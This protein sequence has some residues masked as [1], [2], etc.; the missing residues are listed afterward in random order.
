MTAG[1]FAF[2][3]VTATLLTLPVYAAPM[4]EAHPVA[5][6]ID[7][8]SLGSVVDPVGDAV[9]V[10]DGE[11]QPSGVAE[12]VAKG[13]VPETT[14]PETTTPESTPAS[15][16]VPD[17]GGE[18]AGVPALTV[19]QEGAE[20]FSSVGVTWREDASVTDVVVQLRV[21]GTD[22]A[23]DEWTSLE[24]DDA[25]QNE[26]AAT[27]G[28]VRAGTAPYWTGEAQGVQVIVQAEDGD[29]PEDVR[30]ALIDPGHSA[31]DDLATA[32][33]TATAHAGAAEPRIYTR[34]E[35]GADERIRSW[36]PEYVST[37]KAA[38]VHHTADGNN[39]SAEQVPAILRSMYAYHA[40]TR[41]WG[42]IGYN[43][44]VDRYGRVFEGRYGGLASTVVG[45]HAGGFNSY[46]FGV[47]MLGNYDVVPV[48]QAT[49]DAVADVIAWKFG[50][51]GVDPRGTTVLTSGG[52]GTAR[53]GGG[54]K[55]TLPTVFGHRDVGSTA[56]PGAYGYARL[57]EV[58]TRVIALAD[59]SLSA[60]ARR[61]AAEPALRSS[62]G[63]AVGD[64]Q[65]GSGFA[66]QRYEKGRLYWSPTA[67]VRLVRGDVLTAYL[68]AG[69]PAVLGAPVTDE[70][71]AG[72]GGA[73]NQFAN[74]AAIYWTAGT[75]AQVVRGAIRTRWSALGAE[76]GLGFPTSGETA[77]PGGVQQTFTNGSVYWAAA[78]GAHEL[79]GGVAAV[80]SRAGGAAT[81]GLP[82]TGEV[83]APGGVLQ[84]FTRGY[85]VTWTPS[86]VHVVAGGIR[87]AWVA[88][89]G[90]AGT[91]G[92]PLSDE[93]DTPRGGG[94]YTRFT[95][96][97]IT[98]TS[99]TG[100]VALTG[101]IGA[102]WQAAGGNESDLGLPIGPEQATA[103]GTGRVLT[104]A[105]GASI[106]LTQAGR[107]H[108][109]QGDVAAR[110][111]QFGGVAGLGGPVTEELP[112]GSGAGVYQLFT[113]GK[114]VW[115]PGTGAQP[116]VG[117][118]G[119][120]YDAL[121][122]EYSSLGLPTTAEYAVAEGTR[123]DYQRG[124]I[125]FTGA[126]VLVRHD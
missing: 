90:A 82:M 105:S 40:Q 93:T 87:D 34:A 78:T 122:A 98:W 42:D 113:R 15:V 120:A 67:G 123:Q 101:P 61:Y 18:L 96:G 52:G 8:I 60:I 19:S 63:K 31:A 9:V 115:T 97:A 111:T 20:R 68:A 71:T 49:V 119:R 46:T 45:A 69:G 110:W 43:V 25:E 22:G 27:G 24:P 126:G 5:P 88:A 102:R 77:V 36:A 7:E 54:T 124:S 16:E 48:P 81:L 109:L 121:G 64:E 26:R 70:D 11:V 1:F 32:L 85:T 89:K 13:A 103:D 75:Q 118:I 79:R 6:S 76:W 28:D 56:C 37:I 95:G 100:G 116:V 72:Q 86:R 44:I 106:H 57:G 112:L 104:F 59:N 80:W 91:L 3:A 17:S 51:Y 35:W 23:W 12:S 92:M 125:T 65:Y 84:E 62:L 99:V 41:G 74:D 117:A 66:W 38:T 14:V 30:V 33:P 73:Y 2:L 108:L 47:S 50:L 107:A 55:V 114:M 58:R 39:Y 53:Y 29:V 83:G 21:Q 4:P 10:T 94:R